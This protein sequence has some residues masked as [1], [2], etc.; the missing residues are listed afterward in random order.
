MGVDL[1]AARCGVPTDFLAK[2]FTRLTEMRLL[3][4]QRG[5]GGGFALTRNPGSIRVA[6]FLRALPTAGAEVRRCLI[7]QKDCGQGR[8]CAIH[9]TVMEAEHRLTEKF[10]S[11]TLA[12][13]VES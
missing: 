10:E 8:P 3:S 1:V 11:L 9:D 2:I 13:L 5:P 6:E 12:D 4:S 7:G